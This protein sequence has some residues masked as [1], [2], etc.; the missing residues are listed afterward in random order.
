[1]T[2]VVVEGE[3]RFGP[4]TG[5]PRLQLSKPASTRRNFPK[6]GGQG[7][8]LR[9][10]PRTFDQAFKEQANCLLRRF[11]HGPRRLSQRWETLMPKLDGQ[12]R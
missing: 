5:R 12:G 11:C 10:L 4:Q 2:K 3:I 7:Q 1:M 6:R 8:G 9:L